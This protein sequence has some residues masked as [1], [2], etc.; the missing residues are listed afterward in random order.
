MDRSRPGWPGSRSVI[1]VA[2]VVLLGVALAVLGRRGTLTTL[3][4]AGVTAAFAAFAVLGAVA[5]WQLVE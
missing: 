1:V 4:L 3:R 5:H 2:G